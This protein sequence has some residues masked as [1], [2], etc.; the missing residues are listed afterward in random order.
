MSLLL[1]YWLR[2]L[3][4]QHVHFRAGFVQSALGEVILE[5]GKECLRFFP[6][7]LLLFLFLD[8]LVEDLHCTFSLGWVLHF[9]G[10]EWQR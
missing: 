1:V 9:F 10:Q 8:G 3:I 2:Y 7:K 5:T 6:A 4:N